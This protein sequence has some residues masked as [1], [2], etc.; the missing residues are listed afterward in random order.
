MAVQQFPVPDS[1]IPKGATAA[2]PAAPTIGTVFYDGTTG[3]LIIWD[4]SAWIP[5]SAPAAQPTISVADVGTSRPYSAAQATVTFTAGSGGGVATGYTVTSSTGGY[6]STGATTSQTITVGTQG[7]WVFSG[8]A[9]NGFGISAASPSQTITL[10]TNPEAASAVTATSNTSNANIAVAWTLGATGGKNLSAVSIVPFLNGTTEQ[11]VTSVATSATTGT[12]TGLTGG[13]SYTFKIRK[14]NANGTTDSTAS[15]SIIVPVA[16]D[17]LI[18]AGGG[19]GAGSSGGEAAGGGGAGGML[20]GTSVLTPG[21]TTTVTVGTGGAGSPFTGTNGNPGTNSIFGAITAAQGGGRGGTAYTAGGGGGSGGAPGSYNSTQG[22]GTAGQGNNSGGS[23]G[24]GGGKGATG[25]SG[26]TGEASSITGSSVTYAA[27]GLG[28]QATP[29][30]GAGNTGNGGGGS[31]NNGFGLAGGSGVVIIA[32]P[33][34]IA[35]PTATTGS[36][37]TPTRT[38]YRVYRWTGSGSITF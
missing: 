38:G 12:V 7:S 13:S 28:S 17:Y 6:S 31:L 15:S 2:R 4:G 36:P 27:G 37:S 19:G 22:A 8:T 20:T 16:I 10:T 29:V 32:Y 5:C 24:N 9:Y 35:A 3:S 21:V 34:T 11:T 23:G 25:G 18:V 14:T 30:V 1:G 26:G 33:D